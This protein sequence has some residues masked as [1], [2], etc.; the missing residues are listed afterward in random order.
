MTPACCT[1]PQL[2]IAPPPSMQ[3][4]MAKMAGGP[5]PRAGGMDDED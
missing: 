4:I 2:R 1:A 5:K 3:I